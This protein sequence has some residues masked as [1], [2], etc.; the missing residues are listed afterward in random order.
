MLISLNWLR[1]FV[2]I[3]AT[4]DPRGLAE[5]FTIRTAEVE[6]VE[7]VTRLPEGV[8]LAA[9]AVPAAEREDWVIEVDNKSITHRPD[10]W[11]HY[12]IAREIAAMLGTKL[13]PYPITPAE[14][15]GDAKAAEVPIVIDDPAKCPRYTALVFAGLKDQAAPAAMQ[16]RLGRCGM[17]PI[18]LL[19]D[20]TN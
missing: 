17:R 7:H 6:G 8:R 20:L 13:K 10:L 1:E 16:I 2:D 4:L 3:P 5:R 9:G 14:Q 15:L 11:G 18:S 19:V 12:G